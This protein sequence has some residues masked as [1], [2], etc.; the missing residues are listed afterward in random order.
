MTKQRKPSGFNRPLRDTLLRV[1]GAATWDTALIV[2]PDDA[3]GADLETVFLENDFRC[4]RAGQDRDPAT[5]LVDAQPSILVLD[6]TDPRLQSGKFYA[7]C[8]AEFAALKIPAIIL[9]GSDQ[10]VF[11]GAL[12]EVALSR[13][14]TPADL[15]EA[16]KTAR[17]MSEN[18]PE[19][20]RSAATSSDPVRS[21][22]EYRDPAK[23]TGKPRP[24]KGQMGSTARYE[25]TDEVPMVVDAGAPTAPNGAAITPT[26]SAKRK[27]QRFKTTLSFKPQSVVTTASPSALL[28]PPRRDDPV[29]TMAD[30]TPAGGVRKGRSPKPTTKLGASPI[31][32]LR[33]PVSQLALGSGFL[34]PGTEITTR[35]QVVGVLGAGGMATVYQC[36]D[37]EFEEDVA[38]KLI[39]QDRLDEAT[40][41]RFRHEMRVCRRLSHT[42]IVRTYEFGTWKG[43]RF[44][45]MELLD[46]RDLS[47]VLLIAQGPLDVQRG[48]ALTRQAC[49][50][51][52]AAHLEGV[53]HRDIKPHNMF[54]T[55]G[56]EQLKIMDFGI[57][58]TGDL[59]LTVPGSDRVLGTPAYLAPERLKEKVD[60]TA[61]TDIYSLGVVMY[62]MFTGSLPF[63]AP[64]ISSLLTSIVL[65]E[66]RP[67]S[68]LVHSISPHIEAIILRAMAKKP[69][70]RYRSCQEMI[71]ELDTVLL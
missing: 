25:G 35:Y 59:T 38:L 21:T 39:K 71:A 30:S 32:K 9:G 40:L 58:K 20:R 50:G 46:G 69:S 36:R 41:Q 27:R 63:V 19:P 61:R 31:R 28:V 12:P 53:I 57:A 2:Q 11:D 37:K 17:W 70:D 24:E 66:P 13:G 60:L 65:E 33:R 45:T 56:D 18:P 64:D 43:R 6:P 52:G 4:V 10:T 51:L 55:D 15:R 22:S 44:I 29:D 49:L 26:T 14:F 67:P 47:Q 34:T 68:E 8:K 48:L 62:Q 7:A 16:I 42:N 5:L 1:S 54:V 3:Q 23:S